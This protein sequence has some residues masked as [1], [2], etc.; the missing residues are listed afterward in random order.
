M[1][2]QHVQVHYLKNVLLELAMLI[3]PLKMA[4][5]LVEIIIS[6]ITVRSTVEY[7][8][9]CCPCVKYA[10]VIV[11]VIVLR[12]MSMQSLHTE[13]PLLILAYESAQMGMEVTVVNPMWVLAMIHVTYASDQ[14]IMNVFNALKMHIGMLWVSEYAISIIVVQTVKHTTITIV[15]QYETGVKDQQQQ[16]E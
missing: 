9:Q 7:V 2:A 3:D 16:T 13:V 1:I 6:E 12:D 8:I 10:L 15:I 11:K 5:V 4:H 14:L